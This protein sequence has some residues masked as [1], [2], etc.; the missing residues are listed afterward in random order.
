MTLLLQE[1]MVP[2]SKPSPHSVG[3]GSSVKTLLPLKE[4]MV[5]HDFLLLK[6]AVDPSSRPFSLLQKAMVPHDTFPSAGGDD[7]SLM[8]LSPPVGGDF[9]FLAHGQGGRPAGV[10][11]PAVPPRAPTCA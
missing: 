6:E 10:A 8:P 5:L 9:F 2:R 11:V 1:A 3:D 7:S 4:T